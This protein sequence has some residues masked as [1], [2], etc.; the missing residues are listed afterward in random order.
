MDES[1]AKG[2]YLEKTNLQCDGLIPF[3]CRRGLNRH[4]KT[5]RAGDGAANPF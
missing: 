2:I 3:A 1:N 4:G 5:M